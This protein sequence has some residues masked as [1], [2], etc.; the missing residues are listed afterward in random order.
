MLT[1]FLIRGLMICLTIMLIRWLLI[2][3]KKKQ[4]PMSRSEKKSAMWDEANNRSESNNKH[5]HSRQ[6]H[7]ANVEAM[8]HQV[9][10]GDLNLSEQEVTHLSE[11]YQ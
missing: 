8:K 4:P 11:K 1:V 10:S 7:T 6:V 9:D 5:Q 3:C 2:Y